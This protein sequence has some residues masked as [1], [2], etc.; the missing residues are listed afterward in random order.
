MREGALR[1][2]GGGTY[3]NEWMAARREKERR[4]TRQGGRKLCWGYNIGTKLYAPNYT[5]GIL[6]RSTLWLFHPFLNLY[7][8]WVVISIC[9]RISDGWWI[10][11]IIILCGGKEVEA[12]QQSEGRLE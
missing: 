6:L 5:R 4:K 11:I 10:R 8:W 9:Q 3:W 2:G 12:A 1:R 7:F